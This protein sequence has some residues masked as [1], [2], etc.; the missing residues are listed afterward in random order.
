MTAVTWTTDKHVVEIDALTGDNALCTWEIPTLRENLAI[1]QRQLTDGL[2]YG[3]MFNAAH[4]AFRIA[5]IN[6]ELES[7]NFNDYRFTIRAS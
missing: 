5:Q 6:A 2:N 3:D 1:Y 4:A 7:R